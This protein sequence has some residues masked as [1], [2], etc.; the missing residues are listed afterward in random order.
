MIIA[1]SRIIGTGATTKQLV[2]RQLKCLVSDLLDLFGIRH[3]KQRNT[4]H[5]STRSSPPWRSYAARAQRFPFAIARRPGPHPAG[6]D[7]SVHTRQV[8]KK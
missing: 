6:L 4:A 5:C 2:V 3:G 1:S 7:L 8:T